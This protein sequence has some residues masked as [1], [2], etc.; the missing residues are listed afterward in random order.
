M[1]CVASRRRSVMVFCVHGLSHSD[2]LN[3]LL[4]LTGVDNTHGQNEI[5]ENDLRWNC[6]LTAGSKSDGTDG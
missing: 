4:D 3:H 6:V 2:S 1:L 5:L